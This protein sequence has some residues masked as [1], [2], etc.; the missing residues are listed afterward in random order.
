MEEFKIIS[1]PTKNEEVEEEVTNEEIDYDD[2]DYE[3]PKK[4]YFIVPL[5][6]VFVIIAVVVI[7]VVTTYKDFEAENTWQR[8]D[9]AESQYLEFNNNLLKYSSDGIFYTTY[10]GALIWNYTYDMRNPQVNICEEYLVVYDKKGTEVDIFSKEGFVNTIKMNT[11]IMEAQIAGQGIVAV[12]MQEGNTSFIQMFNTD[13]S[14]L[15]SGEIHPE[16]GGYPISLALSSDAKRMMISMINLNDGNVN[17][18]INFYDFSSAGKSE[19]DNIV[20]SYNYLGMII[21]EVEFLKGDKAVA[22]GDKEIIIYNNNTKATVEKEILVQ[23]EMK[24]ILYN[25]SYIG[26]IS[27]TPN[28]K[29]EIENQ[30]TVYNLYGFRSLSKHFTDKYEKISLMSNNEILLKNGGDVAIYNLQGFKK[31]AYSFGE[32]I[33]QMI[34]GTTMHRYYLIEENETKEIHLK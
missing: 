29:G 5:F 15:V 28:D 30:I 13:G 17:T 12:L 14:P 24:S 18:V 21:P 9:A 22:F 1:I 32:N 3:P 2:G 33:Y 23:E 16:N 31:F 6:I 7:Q 4:R 27:E 10:S 20:A 34:P 19:V 26:Y 8:K 11:P 25:E